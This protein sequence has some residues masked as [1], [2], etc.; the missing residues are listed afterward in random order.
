M[1]AQEM[2]RQRDRDDKNIKFAIDKL[3]YG[4]Y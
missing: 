2:Q 3:N 1:M 4:F